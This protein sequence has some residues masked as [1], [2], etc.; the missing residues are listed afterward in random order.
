LN[1]LF[2]EGISYVDGFFVLEVMNL[3]ADYSIGL[4]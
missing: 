4:G 2:L 1:K 3:E